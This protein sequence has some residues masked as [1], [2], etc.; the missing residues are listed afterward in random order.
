MQVCP[1][2]PNP[3]SCL[4][5]LELPKQINKGGVAIYFTEELIK[6]D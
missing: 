2:S 4:E 5:E 1:H 3:S 6:T